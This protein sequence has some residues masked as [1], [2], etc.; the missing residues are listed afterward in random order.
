MGF[1]FPLA[2]AFLCAFLASTKGRNVVGWFIIGFIFNVLALIL[3][4]ILP[5]LKLERQRHGQIHAEQHRQRERTSQERLR[6]EAFERHALARLDAHDVHAGIDTRASAPP[7][8]PAQLATEASTWYYE[9]GG[10][11]CGPIAQADLVEKFATGKLAPQTLVW[12]E[13]ME[14]WA[15]AS[16]VGGF[17]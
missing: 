16:R 17:A 14:D 5:D 13:G 12:R 6:R 3:L 9:L 15:P 4:A 8:L 2:F 1:L 10:T 11:S 7:P